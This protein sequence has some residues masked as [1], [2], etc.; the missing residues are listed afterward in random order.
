MKGAPRYTLWKKPSRGGFL[1]VEGAVAA[2][3]AMVGEEAAP[4][5]ADEGGANQGFRLVGREADED[6]LHEMFDV[7]ELGSMIRSQTEPLFSC[8]GPNRQKL[9]LDRPTTHR[10]RGGDHVVDKRNFLAT[11]RSGNRGERC[12]D[13]RKTRWRGRGG[14]GSRRRL[15]LGMEDDGDGFGAHSA[16]S[17]H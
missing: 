17:L 3:E 9:G 7:L 12:S 1:L 11:F 8:T 15:D 13:S 10:R 16:D 2:A 4:R 6:R 5:L 14:R